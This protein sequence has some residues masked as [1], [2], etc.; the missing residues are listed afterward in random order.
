[1]SYYHSHPDKY[2]L[3]VGG[4]LYP[5]NK[6]E[7]ERCHS[8]TW[9]ENLDTYFIVDGINLSEDIEPKNNEAKF[10]KILEREMDFISNIKKFEI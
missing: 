6:F 10:S 9:F 8:E 3:K 7:K 1:M 2:N 4:L 5:M